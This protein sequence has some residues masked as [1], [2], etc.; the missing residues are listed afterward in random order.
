M[1][2]EQLSQ[3]RAKLSRLTNRVQSDA[4][5]IEEMT[6]WPS[7]GQ[8]TGQLSNLPLHLGDQGTEE[9]LAELN[10]T[11]LENEFYIVSESVA[12][13]A[14]IDAGSFGTCENCGRPINNER[15]Q[16]IPYT[17]FCVGC[18]RNADVPQVNLNRGQA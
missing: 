16:A 18:A 17:R 8:A 12:A 10:A 3:Y 14:R 4:N 1:N 6:R 2:T 15:L 5:R 11:L 7:G 13:L 9:Y